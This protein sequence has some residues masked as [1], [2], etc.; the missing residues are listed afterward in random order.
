MMSY[1][2]SCCARHQ[3]QHG[4][5][6]PA[7]DADVLV[8]LCSRGVLCDVTLPRFGLTHAPTTPA[9]DTHSPTAPRSRERP[10]PPPVDGVVAIPAR[11]SNEAHRV[12]P[13]NFLNEGVLPVWRRDT[14]LGL[15]THRV[16]PQQHLH[17]V[18]DVSVSEKARCGLGLHHPGEGHACQRKQCTP[19]PL[20]A[21]PA[22]AG[23]RGQAQDEQ[24]QRPPCPA[25]GSTGGIN[26][27]RH[28]V[29]EQHC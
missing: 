10:I 11:L 20:Q 26:Q 6:E 17:S 5:Q 21:S 12:L 8:V 3:P 18:H 24:P 28:C 2:C 13:C 15:T 4:M 16:G 23:A 7:Q 29:S 14:R 1:G 19:T 22:A 27:S 25:P 9:R